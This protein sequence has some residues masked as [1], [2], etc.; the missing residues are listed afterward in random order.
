MIERDFL[1]RQ[2]NLLVQALAKVL[3][4]KKMYEYPQAKREIDGAYKSLLGVSSDFIHQ[5]SDV[6]LIEQMGKDPETSGV[7]CYIL[8]ALLKEEAEIL[9][10][11]KKED[12]SLVA[13]LKS[14]SLLLTA[15]VG[16]GTVVEPEHPKKIDEVI[17]ALR[18]VELPT[19]AKEKLFSFYELSGRFDK[20]ENV[21]FELVE[22]DSDYTPIG[23]S[24]YEG[25]LKKSSEE[26]ANGGLPRNEVLD[27]LQSLKQGEHIS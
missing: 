24:F 22:I 13:Y 6:Q 14:V 26:L 16:A 27:G 4:H 12:E 8:G 3:L 23:I 20:A 21:L 1:M 7:K 15:F 19:H 11:E 5:F 17:E 2:I 18:T 10:V 25:L 9:M